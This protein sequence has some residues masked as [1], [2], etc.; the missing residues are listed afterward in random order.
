[1]L[2]ERQRIRDAVELMYSKL[3]YVEKVKKIILSRRF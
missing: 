2:V 1:M 3:Q